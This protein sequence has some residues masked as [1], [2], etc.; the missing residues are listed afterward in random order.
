MLLLLLP[1]VF[2]CSILAQVPEDTI[3]IFPYLTG[4]I[5]F[6][7]YFEFGAGGGA[8]A[9]GMGGTGLALARGE[10]AYSWNPA[11]MIFDEKPS[12]GL[13]FA[14]VSDKFNSVN[15]AYANYP[16]RAGDVVKMPFKSQ[17]FN[18]DFSGFSVP[19][20]FMDRKWAVGGGFHK[21]INM[22]YKSTSQGN[23]SGQD[24]IRSDGSIDAVS[25]A[26][27]NRISQGFGIG[28]TANI[29]MRGPELN[30]YIGNSIVMLYANGIID[31][32]DYWINENMSYSAASFDIG[33][34]GDLGMVKSG[35]VLHAPYKLKSDVKQ[36][37]SLMIQPFPV[38]EIDRYTKTTDIPFGISFGVAVNPLQKLTAAFDINYHN[39][40]DSKTAIEWQQIRMADTTF[41]P[42]YS[43]ILQYGAGLE[44]VFDAGFVNLPIRI[45]YRNNPSLLKQVLK[46]SGND[47]S[48][49]SQENTNIITFGSGLHF[50]KAWMDVA[51]QFGKNSFTSVQN[52]FGI[53]TNLELK[54][55]YSRL[56]ISAGMN[57]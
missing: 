15:W 42:E 21:F 3:P 44:Y 53:D 54:R 35:L 46:V 57:F 4:A 49:G 11:A 45:G 24:Q 13:Q 47:I 20:T 55:D 22:T 27:A 1:L 23:F 7:Q 10:M 48:Y 41:N 33:F 25:F 2:P 9:M 30:N 34:S 19:F 32:V 37:R 31:T 43:D 8:R 38:G 29:L 51:Y 5:Y 50:E 52:Y 56:F 36:T 6:P 17:M 12:I 40:S 18:L 39:M 14:S 26:V 16:D 28:A